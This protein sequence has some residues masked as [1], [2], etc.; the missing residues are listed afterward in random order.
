MISKPQLIVKAFSDHAGCAALA[1]KKKTKQKIGELLLLCHFFTRAKNDK[2]QIKLSPCL[3]GLDTQESP[4]FQG[5][6][7]Y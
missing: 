1:I 6:N 3:D 4:E 2:S 5:L 7:P